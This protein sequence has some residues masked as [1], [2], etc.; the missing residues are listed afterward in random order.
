MTKRFRHPRASELRAA[1]QAVRD[2]GLPVA[3]VK[4]QWSA[5]DDGREV[6]TYSILTVEEAAPTVLAEGEPDW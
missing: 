4:I 3:S 6:T 2:A 5:S 1:V